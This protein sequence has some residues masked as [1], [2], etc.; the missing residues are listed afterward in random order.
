MKIKKIKK[1]MWYQ[2]FLFRISL[3]NKLKTIKNK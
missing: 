3:K 2:I 1:Q